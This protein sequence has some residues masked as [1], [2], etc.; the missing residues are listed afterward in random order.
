MG[1]TMHQRY[2]RLDFQ[3]LPD[4]LLNQFNEINKATENFSDKELNDI[5]E[6]EFNENYK[7]VEK[8]YPAAI[9]KGGTVRK[10]KP[11]K[12]KVV[13]AKE[14]KRI[15]DARD[16]LA[17]LTPKQEKILE[18]RMRKKLTE[19]EIDQIEDIFE[20]TTSLDDK[21][22]QMILVAQVGLSESQATK[23]VA[24]RDKYLKL[25]GKDGKKYSVRKAAKKAARKGKDEKNTLDGY[26]FNQ[27]D[28]AMRG[29][30][31]FDAKGNVWICEGYNEKAKECMAKKE[32]NKEATDFCIEDM[33]VNNPIAK[34]EKGNLVDDCKETLK[35]A[36]YIVREHKAGTKKIKRSEPRPEKVIIKE[37]VEDTFTPIMKELKGS[38]EKEK[39]NKQIIVVLESIQFKFT[40]IMNRISNLADDNRLEALKKILKLLDE[41]VG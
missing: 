7:L 10:E 41:I 21:G 11:A 22:L 15:E 36:G 16:F 38:E 25:H 5:M 26:T 17:N 24:Y 1:L 14:A 8:Y 12:V 34:R 4:D 27:K 32:G 13:K 2:A 20:K 29:K 28:P 39:E 37:R 33:Y 3:K 35:E 9:K 40:T 31:F 30:K 23:W 18:S 6:E 19:S